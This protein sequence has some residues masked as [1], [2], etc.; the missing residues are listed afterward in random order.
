MLGAS[1][2]QSP[3]IRHTVLCM[4]CR[5]TKF[6]IAKR[7][8][9]AHKLSGFHTIFYLKKFDYDSATAVMT[10]S[11]HEELIPNCPF[12]GVSFIPQERLKQW[13]AYISAT[14]KK[15]LIKHF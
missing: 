9:R 12:Y 6:L 8:L 14:F 11:N 13:L 4:L 5:T 2:S 1:K 3:L 10:R 15:L 7:M